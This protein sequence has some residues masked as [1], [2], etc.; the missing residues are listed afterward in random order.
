MFK[1]VIG[2]GVYVLAD[3]AFKCLYLRGYTRLRI[4]QVFSIY[5]QPQP[6]SFKRIRKVCEMH[7][8]GEC[9]FPGCYLL[10]QCGFRKAVNHYV[11]VIYG[12]QC[13]M[14]ADVVKHFRQHVHCFE[15]NTWHR[16][17]NSLMA[18]FLSI[19]PEH[20]YRSGPI[21][22]RNDFAFVRNTGLG[23]V[24]SQRIKSS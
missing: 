7:V 12:C 9:I 21:L 1:R 19:E 3:N 18:E 20:H 5:G 11:S 24:G 23:N 13:E 2:V 22:V 16:I 17:E 14:L 15:R 10:G 4:V 8:R 6:D